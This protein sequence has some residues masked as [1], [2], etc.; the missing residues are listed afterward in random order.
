MIQPM[1]T[2]HHG[3]PPP[4]IRLISIDQVLAEVLTVEPEAF[5]TRYGA[6]L[7]DALDWAREIVDQTLLHHLR[8]PRSEPY[9]GYVVVDRANER[10]I[11]V[12][13][14]AH[15]PD[16]RGQVEIAYGTFPP[17]EGLGFGT[18]MAKALTQ[19]AIAAPE[20]RNV[21]AHTLPEANGSTRILEKNGFRRAGE[22]Q[23]PDAGVVWR[24]VL[25]PGR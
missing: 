2:Q 25:D 16:D 12:C 6:T 3:K 18:A 21:I 23:D 14:F 22:A 7:G 4:A 20:V 15:G 19:L 11:G 8:V 17:F 10:V 13:G 1:P 9:G 24:W 5:N